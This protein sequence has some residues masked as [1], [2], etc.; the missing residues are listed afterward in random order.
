MKYNICYTFD[1]WGKFKLIILHV[2]VFFSKNNCNKVCLYY[3]MWC[4]KNVFHSPLV[5]IFVCKTVFGVQNEGSKHHQ[6]KPSQMIPSIVSLSAIKPGLCQCVPFNY[7]DII[8]SVMLWSPPTDFLLPIW[9]NASARWTRDLMSGHPSHSAR[10]HC[11]T[12]SLCHHTH[13]LISQHSND[14]E[15]QTWTVY[16]TICH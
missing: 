16:G 12:L 1:I 3:C 14:S 13:P 7:E 6:P 9:L 10:A 5:H 4:L 15:I 8:L 11:E 2:I